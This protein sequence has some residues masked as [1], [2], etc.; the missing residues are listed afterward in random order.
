MDKVLGTDFRT[1]VKGKQPCFK[2]FGMGA[3]DGCQRSHELL[4]EPTNGMINGIKRRFRAGVDRY[5]AEQAKD[6][7]PPAEPKSKN[8]TYVRTRDGPPNTATDGAA[9]DDSSTG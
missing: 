2:H 4:Q 1:I 7:E 6:S 3:C 8:K 5:L 9:S